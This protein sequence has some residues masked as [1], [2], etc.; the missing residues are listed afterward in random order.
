MAMQRSERRLRQAASLVLTTLFALLLA[1]PS[2]SFAQG[3][4]AK[5]IDPIAGIVDAFKTNDVVALG[6][7]NHGNEQGAVF[8][9]KLYR[10]PRFQAAVNDIVVESGNGRYQEMM[11][12]YIAGEA[13][14]EKELRKAWIETTQPHDVWDR[15]IYADVFRTIREVNQKLP[16]AKQ[17]RVLLGDTPY[18]YDPAN[19]A[20]PM[21]RTDSFTAELVQREV[22]AKKHKALMIFGGMHFLRRQEQMP[23]EVVNPPPRPGTIVTLLE[24][25]G[26][27]VFTVWTFAAI[28]AA[29]DLNALQSDITS[30]P[31]PSLTLI[32]GTT[33]GVAPFTFYY[34]KGAGRMMV[35]GPNG[36]ITLDVGEAIGGT[37]QDQADAILYLAPKSEITMARLSKSLC[38]DPDY[39]EMRVKRMS[40]MGPSGASPGAGSPGDAFRMR[41]NAVVKGPRNTPTPGLEALARR[42]M[43]GDA[44]GEPALGIISPGLANAAQNQRDGLMKAYAR[45]GPLQSLTFQ[46]ATSDGVGDTYL[47][48]F[49]YN[50]RTISIMPGADGKVMGFL[51]GPFLPQTDAQLKASFKAIDLN[52]DG[53]LDQPEYRTMLDKIG[54][55]Q[56]FDTLFAQI[57]D[58]KDGV[59]TAK[60]YEAHPQQ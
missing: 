45:S 40:A 12:R 56:M 16:K 1:Q 17:L 55:S 9:D 50:S 29:Q 53:K 60:E 18:T 59:L 33:L 35:R 19:L 8:R 49:E 54:F 48:V 39:I 26:A 23:P 11:D 38:A 3:A 22:I 44:K 25:A 2:P 27:K 13:V 34:P 14:P 46:G 32:K 24:K 20:A 10:D 31:K 47:A 41:C 21:V 30:W 43:A 42:I 4:L 37:M 5:P 51:M 28:G 6:E 52:S 15:D 36:P 58:D 7:G 57:D